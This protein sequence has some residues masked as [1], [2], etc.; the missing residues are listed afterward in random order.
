MSD[1]SDHNVAT[2]LERLT[3]QLKLIQLVT[4]HPDREDFLLT[5]ISYGIDFALDEIKALEVQLKVVKLD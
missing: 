4:E 1:C 3:N 2:R 5:A